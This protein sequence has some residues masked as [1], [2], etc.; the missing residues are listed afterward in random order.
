MI[1]I[2]ITFFIT[3]IA[4]VFFRSENISSALSYIKNIFSKSL[5]TT[6]NLSEISISILG[7]IGLFIIIEWIQR[8]QEHG[9]DFRNLT[10]SKPFRWTIY[11]TIILLISFFGGSQEEFIYFQF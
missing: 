2:G 9:L 11:F 8:E 5:L 6:P 10:L 3:T 1:Q 4:W 7:V